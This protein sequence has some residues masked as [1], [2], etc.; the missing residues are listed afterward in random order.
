MSGTL[1]VRDPPAQVQEV[2]LPP[3]DGL[4][5]NLA[6]QNSSRYVIENGKRSAVMSIGLVLRAARIGTLAL[7]PVTV[8][9]ANGASLASA[10]RKVR[11]SGHRTGRSCSARRPRPNPVRSMPRGASG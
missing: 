10:S 9:L 2:S 1:V 8:R 6:N 4:E 3:V 5:W 11:A 7:P